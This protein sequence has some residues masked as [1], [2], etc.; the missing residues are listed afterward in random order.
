MKKRDPSVKKENLSIIVENNANLHLY[1]RSLNSIKNIISNSLKQLKFMKTLLLIASLSFV[2]IGHFLNK[3]NVQ[4]FDNQI[5]S[6]EKTMGKSDEKSLKEDAVKIEEE[7]VPLVNINE[8]LWLKKK[9]NINR[10]YPH[11]LMTDEEHLAIKAQEKEILLKYGNTFWQRV[12]NEVALIEKRNLGFK[13][14]KLKDLEKYLKRNNYTTKISDTEFPKFISAR[15]RFKLEENGKIGNIDVD[16]YGYE[17]IFGK[18][19]CAKFEAN[20][21]QILAKMRFCKPSTFLNEA[22]EDNFFLEITQ[23]K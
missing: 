7:D 18:D 10:L 16:T 4:G 2:F 9:Y 12:K 23:L 8:H 1:L 19:N 21:G 13:R 22:I 15:V 3:I 20:L 11:C 17:T 14:A 6:S 5:I